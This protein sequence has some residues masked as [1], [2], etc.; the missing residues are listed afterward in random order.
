LIVIEKLAEP[1]APLASVAVTAKLAEPAEVGVPEMEPL[2]PR[3]RPA[4]KAPDVTAY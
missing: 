2:D 1:V 4:G 3:A